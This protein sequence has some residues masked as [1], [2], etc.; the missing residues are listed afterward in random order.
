MQCR[1]HSRRN[2]SWYERGDRGA[3]LGWVCVT[4]KE[5]KTE[6]KQQQNS[7]RRSWAKATGASGPQHLLDQ[8]TGE[9]VEEQ[10][11][12]EQQQQQPQDFEDQPAVVVPDEVTNGLQ[13]AQKPHETGVRSTSRRRGIEGKREGRVWEEGRKERRRSK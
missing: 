8:V 2:Y 3:Q 11:Q 9:R 12:Q 1:G 7:R 5:K 13:R 10:A 6:V 4:D